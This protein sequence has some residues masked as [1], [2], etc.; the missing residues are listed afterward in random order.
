[1]SYSDKLEEIQRRRA[2]LRALERLAES[3][4]RNMSPIT[5]DDERRMYADQAV[6]DQAYV[7]AGRRA[8]PPHP[9]ERPD[10]FKRRLAAGLQSLSTRWATADFQKIPSDALEIAA[11]QVRADALA[12]GR[13]AG[14]QA[15]EIR[16]IP[17]T[18][19]SGHRT[20]E[21]VGGP[22]ASFIKRF[23]RPARRAQFQAPEDYVRMM[24]TAAMQRVGE[25]V[26]TM[27]PPMQA[28][29]AGF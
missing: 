28:P 12:N 29:R 14:L 18:S 19:A 9:F 4:A 8:P 21:F 13:T 20:R 6:F 16:E 25:V 10:S 17:S 24:Q 11:E 5:E 22:E 23:T 3:E 26:R 7:A 2:E 1:M 15:T 27:R